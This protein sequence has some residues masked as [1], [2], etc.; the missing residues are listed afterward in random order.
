[1]AKKLKGGGGRPEFGKPWSRLQQ[2][3]VAL[4][5]GATHWFQAVL[6]L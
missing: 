2:D 1:M 3:M 6:H 4:C 5:S